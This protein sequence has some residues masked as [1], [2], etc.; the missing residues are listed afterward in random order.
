MIAAAMLLGL[1]GPSAARAETPSPAP[2]ATQTEPAVDLPVW[3]RTLYKTLTYQTVANLSDIALYTVLIAGPSAAAGSFFAA[4]ALSA[5]VLYYGFEYTWQTLGPPLDE[6]DAT[7]LAEKT[8]L[9]R[10]INSSRNFALG[11]TF[12]GTAAAA[13]AFVVANFVTDT[14]IFVGNE[15]VWDILE[16]GTSP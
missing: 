15:Y 16:P 5:A 4:N 1:S 3:Q 6:T 7:T 2:D 12:G 10:V 9:Y 8:V 13:G 14:A 11:Y